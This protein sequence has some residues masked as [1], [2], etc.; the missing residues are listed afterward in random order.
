MISLVRVIGDNE[1]TVKE[2]MTL[3]ELKDRVNFRTTY[4]YP[5]IEQGFIQ[6]LYPDQ[7]K[8]R[9]QKYFLT[10]S[11]KEILKKGS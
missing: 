10:D 9:N 4:L 1:Y 3:L 2:M 11:G 5:A 8:H 6:M 7:P